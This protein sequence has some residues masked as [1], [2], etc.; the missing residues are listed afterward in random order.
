MTR[1]EKRCIVMLLSNV[2]TTLK[3]AERF[4]KNHK[5]QKNNKNNSFLSG[6]WDKELS[7]FTFFAVRL[8]SPSFLLRAQCFVSYVLR[9]SSG[10]CRVTLGEFLNKPFIQ[11][12]NFYLSSRLLGKIPSVFTFRPHTPN[13][14]LISLF[15]TTFKIPFPHPCQLFYH[16]LIN[17]Y[18]KKKTF[19]FTGGIFRWDNYRISQQVS[20]DYDPHFLNVFS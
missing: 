15:K 11:S 10:V 6:F 1:N 12:T 13:P 7:I 5:I 9:L 16:G 4:K 19:F 20:F 18:L 17:L 3:T 14:E 8:I 2:S